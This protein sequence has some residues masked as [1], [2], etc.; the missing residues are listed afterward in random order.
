MST[1]T[2]T[3]TI[4]LTIDAPDHETAVKLAELAAAN[5][6]AG[7]TEHLEVT[8]DGPRLTP[9][10]RVH[11]VDR[12]NAA[13]LAVRTAIHDAVIPFGHTQ[14]APHWRH[15]QDIARNRDGVILTR[16]EIQ[17]AISEAMTP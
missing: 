5:A 13:R 12:G 9:F 3:V 15:V 6:A 1:Y 4:P 2:T 11:T 8:A 7:A 17:A 14:T 10:A 16:D